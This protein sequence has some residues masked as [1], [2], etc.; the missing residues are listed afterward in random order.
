MNEW[1]ESQS[2][3]NAGGGSGVITGALML[4]AALVFVPAAFDALNFFDPVKRLLWALMAVVLAVHVWNR[5][6]SVSL[7][8]GLA[9]FLAGWMV[10]RSLLRPL[11]TAELGVL[12][13]WC[14]PILLFYLGSGLSL[15]Q[16]ERRTVGGF[17]VAAGLIQAVLMILQRM[18]LDPLFSATTAAMD[19][20]PGRMV[21]TI[22]YQNQAVDFL[23]LATLGILLLTSSPA[24][25]VCGSVLALPVILLTGYRG[26]ILAFA[27]GVLFSGTLI[28]L[29]HPRLRGNRSRMATAAGALAMFAGVMVIAI[30]GLQNRPGDPIAFI[31]DSHR[32]ADVQ[33]TS[34][35]RLGGG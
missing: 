17:L 12:V 33:G 26:G 23:A 21:G 32:M 10:L 9:V 25:F 2:G 29:A 35:D 6:H 22:G 4:L 20:A 15:N 7:V 30:H 8:S 24:W 19:Y 31:Y 3:E 18:G 11:S 27:I 5:R 16:K 14:L 34:R 13:S 1:R 28:V